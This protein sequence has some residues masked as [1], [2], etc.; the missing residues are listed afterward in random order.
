MA[1][2]HKMYAINVLLFDI[3]QGIVVDIM[4]VS[5][6]DENDENLVRVVASLLSSIGSDT[7]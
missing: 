1:A 5:F 3:H 2:N 7:T 6:E 4:N